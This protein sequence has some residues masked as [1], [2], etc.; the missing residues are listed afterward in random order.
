MNK[1]SLPSLLRSVP[2]LLLILFV[3]SAS[4]SDADAAKV[5][6]LKFGNGAASTTM[7]AGPV[8]PDGT[9]DIAGAPGVRTTNWNNVAISGNN[10]LMT[11]FDGSVVD[12]SGDV[13]SGVTITAFTGQLTGNPGGG[14]GANDAKLFGSI[15]DKDQRN[16]EGSVNI[17]GLPF[18]NYLVFCYSRP[19]QGGGGARG[20]YWSFRDVVT[21]MTFVTNVDFTVTQINA[22]VTNYHTTRWLK[23]A[24]APNGQPTAPPT[25]DANGNGYVRSFTSAQPSTWAQIQQGN[26]VVLPGNPFQEHVGYITNIDVATAITNVE[27]YTNFGN[28]IYFTAVGGGDNGVAGG[29]GARRHKVAGL[30]IVGFPTANLTNI[31]LLSPI[32]NLLAGNTVPTATAPIGL[33]DD[34]DDFPLTFLPGV[35]YDSENANVFTTDS[36]GRIFPQH[37]GTANL[38][39]TSGSVSLTQAVTVLA[40]TAL[41]MSLS[42]TNLFLGNN[43]ADMAQAQVFADFEGALTNAAVSNV[44]VTAYSFV[45]FNPTPPGLVS[46]STGGLIT[47]IGVVGDNLFNIQAAFE[48][49]QANAGG[50][51]ELFQAPGTLPSFGVN[52][53]DGVA[54]NQANFRDLTGAPGSRQAY[55]NNMAFNIGSTTSPSNAVV[56]PRDYHGN[57]LTNTTAVWTSLGFAGV[58]TALSTNEYK[59]IHYAYDSGFGGGAAGST[60][61][62]QRAVVITNVPYGTYDAYFYFW[63]DSGNAARIG[64][65]TAVETGETRWRANMPTLTGS[66]DGIAPNPATGAGYNQAVPLISGGSIPNAVYP[67]SLA[68]VPGGNYIKFSGLTN[69][70]ATFM[71][72]GDGT[73]IVPDANNTVRLRMAAFQIV[74]NVGDLTPT[75]VYLDSVSSNAL[76]NLLP[77]S[78]AGTLLTAFA[79]FTSEDI[80]GADVTELSTFSSS[81]TSIFEVTPNGVVTAGLTA[82]TAS[83]VINFKSVSYTQMV[84]TLAPLSVTLTAKPNVSY[85][86]GG[87]QAGALR[88]FATFPGQ[89]NLDISA[90]NGVTFFDASPASAAVAFVSGPPWTIT[91]QSAGI[92]DLTGNYLGVNYTNLAGFIVRNQY[93]A[94]VQPVN[95]LSDTN[96]PVNSANLVHRYSFSESPGSTIIVDSVGGANGTMIEGLSGSFP[97]ELDG[98]QVNFPSNNVYQTTPYI[99]LPAG[100]ISQRGDIT[101]DMWGG[102]NEVK[103]WSRFFDAG[104]S[105]KGTDTHNAGNGIT[106]LYFVSKPGGAA[107]PRFAATLP[108]GNTLIDGLEPFPVGSEQHV[109]LVYSYNQGSTKMYINGVPVAAGSAIVPLQLLN[110]QNVWLGVSL[111]NDSVLNGWIN[112]IRIYEGAFTDADAAAS[113]VAG[114]NVGLVAKPSLSVQ[115]SGSNVLLSWPVSAADFVLKSNTVLNGTWNTVGVPL[116]TN[117][118]NIEVTV[119]ASSG[120]AFFLL[121][122]P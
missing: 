24:D 114:P 66:L 70:T 7:N 121:Q 29:D 104:S 80:F 83:L 76:R 49:L 73:D 69:A 42:A 43:A 22:F 48:G 91:P 120:D 13:V 77:G 93:D 71:W 85:I 103:D 17:V 6:G 106:S 105:G 116:T 44:N 27:S 35:A 28:T 25:P 10:G 92:A 64:H 53:T 72:G 9:G 57:I 58:S 50:R 97:L 18:T 38:V 4:V 32:P 21:N 54:A 3:V 14:S 65:V 8:A 62:G 68:E 101:I 33:Y 95:V 112:E 31:A 19:D 81:D 36:S 16:A 20:G 79:D 30:Q 61:A 52:I 41:R 26:Y 75:R 117:G 119:P 45:V 56:N 96:N 47:A 11:L 60:V 100:I 15:W 59:V 115:K 40:P 23:G 110:D 39:I 1:P 82:G 86:D 113:D 108:G 98:T 84:T 87:A 37:A 51:V 102:I 118:S 99:R 63:N 107:N 55:W 34:G 5:I 67:A 90:F 94:N 122:R 2:A 46:V 109:T 78:P 74:R 89:T 88:M 12:N 111:W